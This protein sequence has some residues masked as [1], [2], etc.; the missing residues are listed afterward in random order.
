MTAFSH[1]KI[2]LPRPGILPIRLPLFGHKVPA[3]FPSPADDYMEGL[4]SL[5]EE[6]IPHK[7][8]TFFVRARGNSMTGAGI[9]D[10]DLLVVDKSLE[11]LS[12]DI[13]IASVDGDITVKRFIQEGSIIKLRPENSAH[14]EIVFQEGQELQIWG[15]VLS[16][17]TKHKFI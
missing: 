3:G 5:D 8:A 17:T 4:I 9:Y 14:K 15:V 12:G 2:N 13:V 6:L 10:G 11:P 16:S 1:F 7:T